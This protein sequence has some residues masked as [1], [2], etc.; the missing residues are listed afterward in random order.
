MTENIKEIKSIEL[1]QQ[2]GKIL[3]ILISLFLLLT[4]FAVSLTW[5]MNADNGNYFSLGDVI[6]NGGMIYSDAWTMKGIFIPYFYAL[7]TLLFGNVDWGIRL[8]DL[9]I[10]SYGAVAGW[11]IINKLTDKYTAWIITLC[12]QVN[13]LNDYYLSAQPEIWI[14]VIITIMMAI[15]FQDNGKFLK[16]NAIIAGLLLTFIGSIKLPYLILC[17]LPISYAFIYCNKKI[18]DAL[19]F[20]SVT[21]IT[22]ILSTS[23]ILLWLYYN[24]ALESMIEIQFGYAFETHL[25]VAFINDTMRSIGASIHSFFFYGNKIVYTILYIPSMIILWKTKKKEGSLLLVWFAIALFM[26]LAQQKNYGTY[27]LLMIAP[28]VISASYLIGN[29]RGIKYF[30]CCSLLIILSFHHS[31]NNNIKPVLYTLEKRGLTDQIFPYFYQPKEYSNMLS[32]SE[33]INKYDNSNEKLLL[34]GGS[35]ILATYHLTGMKPLTRFIPTFPILFSEGERKKKYEEEILQGFYKSPPK[36]IVYN[37]SEHP[38]FIIFGRNYFLTEKIREMI[39]NN[40]YVQ[41]AIG[42]YIIM[43]FIDLNI[44][45]ADPDYLYLLYYYE[46]I[47]EKEKYR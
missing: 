5:P 12:F 21:G 42:S 28:L 46:A 31:I 43:K 6:L 22:S 36:Y 7:V 17:I 29:F 8:V 40:Y 24:G 16:R 20:I 47:K 3:L 15:L 38:N 39:H 35:G 19:F 32:I 30:I 33:Y 9:V 41:D 26:P 25:K 34:L 11:Y 13:Y 10:L 18:K 45:T 4:L 14:A 23:S 1:I 2:I 27:L 37:H 44:C